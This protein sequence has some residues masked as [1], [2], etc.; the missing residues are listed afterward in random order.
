MKR[1]VAVFTWRRWYG[2]ES[3]VYRVKAN[4]KNDAEKKA[5][6]FAV[7]TLQLSIFTVLVEEVT[8]E[9]SLAVYKQW[10]ENFPD[11]NFPQVYYRAIIPFWQ[12]ACFG[13]NFGG[14]DCEII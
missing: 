13:D 14:N 7:K 5:Q 3:A 1:F 12:A 2:W 9:K 11:L 4:S 6:L 8:A 10:E